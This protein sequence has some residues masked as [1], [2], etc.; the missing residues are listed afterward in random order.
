[1]KK[2]VSGLMSLQPVRGCLC[3]VCQYDSYLMHWSIRLE[4]VLS[5]IW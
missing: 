3:N 1:M 4:M 5:F 2:Y